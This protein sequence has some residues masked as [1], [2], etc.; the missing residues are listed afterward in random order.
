M[1]TLTHDEILKNISF[2]LICETHESARWDTGVRKRRWKAE[3]TQYDRTACNTLFRKAKDWTLGKGV[4]DTVRMSEDT[5][6]L[7]NRLG[8]FCATL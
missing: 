2:A 6:D 1:I 4:P 7:W 5:Y 3:F 8:S